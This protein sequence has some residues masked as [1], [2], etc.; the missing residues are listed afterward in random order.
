MAIVDTQTSS[1][2]LSGF[3]TLPFMRQIGIL[4]GL[5]ISIALGVSIAL[6]SM[7]PNYRPLYSN[8][9][10]EDAGQVIDVLQQAGI[11]YKLDQ[12]TG[13]VLVSGNDIHDARIKLAA[14]GLPRGSKNGVG[15]LNE[16][17]G[18]GSSTFIET[19]RYRHALEAE[20]ARTITSFRGVKSARVHLAIPKQ[21]VF[22]RDKR[23]PSASVFIDTYSS[24][25]I[26]NDKVASI[27]HLVASSIPSMDS[28]KVTVVDNQGNLLTDGSGSNRISM[29][30]RVLN[31]RNQVEGAYVDKIQD[32]LTPLVGLGK[33]RARVSADIDFTAME[34]THESFD[35]KKSVL[36]SEQIMEEK[37]S[38]SSTT[39]GVPGALSNKPKTSGA[40]T[41]AK[42]AASGD[43]EQEGVDT[44]KQA[45]KNYELDK[46]ISH[47]KHQPGSIKR[48]TVAVVVDNKEVLDPKTKE[49]S[50]KPLSKE[51]IAKIELLVKDA[52]GYDKE[53]GDSVNV[54]NSSFAKAKPIEPLPEPSFWQ[55]SWFL[56]LMKQILA[57]LFILILLFGVIRPLL[58]NLASRP[59]P[60]T[61]IQGPDG[62]T[63]AI[64]N[65]AVQGEA[66][67]AGPRLPGKLQSYDDQMQVL[68]GMAVN[69]P[70]RV[71]QVVKTWVNE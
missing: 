38:E 53:R 10:S 29:A 31:Y 11:A 44:K 60:T 23:E 41:S 9:S 13:T 40:S 5:A 63:I 69:D 18:F 48:L 20:L 4:V 24:G 68:Q 61:V 51:E 56:E 67:G 25:A 34:K 59:A 14:E 12:H 33:V 57:G 49:V 3:G 6:W 8:I 7:E 54:L 17:G 52:I 45:T 46:T 62:K 21:S 1:Q 66:G 37:R 35:P 55:Q 2:A 65:N 47:T 30:N 16:A 27:V 26:S 43:V 64:S 15:F 28:A 19:A 71:A 58:R 42:V 32:I 36:R 50:Y 70:K 22:L 39:G